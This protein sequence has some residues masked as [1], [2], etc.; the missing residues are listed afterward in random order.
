MATDKN[1]VMAKSKLKIFDESAPKIPFNVFKS[2]VNFCRFLFEAK[3]FHFIS[4]RFVVIKWLDVLRHNR[5]HK[6]T[7]HLRF[8]T[9]AQFVGRRLKIWKK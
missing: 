1:I 4:S 2:F 8:G 5:S 7:K 9:V 3:S 6:T